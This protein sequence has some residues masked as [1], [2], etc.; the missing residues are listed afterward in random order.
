MSGS[1]RP[2]FPTQGVAIV[3]GG[4][5]G[6]GTAICQALAAAGAD[7]VLTYNK[8]RDKAEA[9]A[10][11][12]R[13][14]GRTA[15]VAQLSLEDADAVQAFIDGVAKRHTIIHSVVYA[16]GPLV[17]QKFLSAVTPA[18][19]KQ[20]LLGDTMACFNLIHASLLQLRRSKGSYVA[21][22]TTALSRWAT[23]DGLS[24]VPKA[25]VDIMMRGIAR[26]EG[27]FGIRANCVA[28]GLIEAGMF[29]QLRDM[30]HLDD[31]YIKA[32]ANNVPLRRMGTA[33]EVADA[34]TFLAS[35]R[36][37]YVT[38]QVIRVDGGF[39]L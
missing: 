28:L 21:I 16:M 12:V 29:H 1:S 33:E 6:I 9:T 15:E 22:H 14:L 3:A 13:A 37:S 30:G 24:A 11:A 5:G 34:V 27:R 25:G 20:Y 39:P 8:N 17:P 10:A 35:A 18:E 32:A 19:M 36:A 7:L 26:E 4:S 31:N 23:R 2:A 38:G